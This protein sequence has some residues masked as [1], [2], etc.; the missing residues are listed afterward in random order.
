MSGKRGAQQRPEKSKPKREPERAIFGADGGWEARLWF[1]T[2][3]GWDRPSRLEI[4]PSP[5]SHAPD[6][7]LGITSRLLRAV[8]MTAM[9][10]DRAGTA[11]RKF[12]GRGSDYTPPPPGSRRGAKG[13]GDEH[14]RRVAEMYLEALDIDR[15]R[16]LVLMAA[17]FSGYSRENVRDWVAVARD[18]GFLSAAQPGRAGAG[19]GP[20]LVRWQE[21]QEGKG[22]R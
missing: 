7:P 10:A 17:R 1:D 13:W 3:L 16:P 11:E 22:K 9:I 19:P 4:L 5:F 8:P 14:F 2:H 21:E 18:R 12:F 6:E 15:R 20:A